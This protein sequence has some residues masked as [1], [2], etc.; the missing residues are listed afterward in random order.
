ML[1]PLQRFGGLGDGD[2]LGPLEH[3]DEPSQLAALAGLARRRRYGRR[4]RLLG[5]LGVRAPRRGAWLLVGALFR[6]VSVAGVWRLEPAGARAL[7]LPCPS[8]GLLLGDME[9]KASHRITAEFGSGGANGVGL[10]RIGLHGA[11]SVLRSR[12]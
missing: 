3:R 7:G 6:V 8:A 11:I 1:L 10:G 4:R 2:A 12:A 5:R 9:V